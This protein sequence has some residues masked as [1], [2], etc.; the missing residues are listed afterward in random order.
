MFWI[1]KFFQ[2]PAASPTSAPSPLTVSASDNEPSAAFLLR[3]Q[4]HFWKAK[5]P[6]A[7]SSKTKLPGTLHALE[8][9]EVTARPQSRERRQVHGRVRRERSHH[10]PHF[11]FGRGGVAL[12]LLAAA[13]CKVSERRL[14]AE[15][16]R[17]AALHRL[18]LV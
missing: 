12:L 10:A 3:R 8:T 18:D 1:I 15:K 4:F 14:E 5:L 2:V 13:R 7:A 17:I 16:R 6:A 9:P 11:P